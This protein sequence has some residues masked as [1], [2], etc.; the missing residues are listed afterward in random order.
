MEDSCKATRVSLLI[1]AESAE[2]VQWFIVRSSYL[3]VPEFIVVYGAAAR[4]D[5]LTNQRTDKP[6]YKLSNRWILLDY[7]PVLSSFCS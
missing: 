5:G 2:M 7:F 1:T 4:K 3:M 6:T